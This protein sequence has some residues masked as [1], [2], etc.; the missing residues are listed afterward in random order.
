MS[1]SST[2]HPEAKGVATG[3][4]VDL[5][6]ALPQMLMDLDELVSAESPTADIAACLS[7]A[8]VLEKIVER[9]LKVKAERVDRGGRRHLCWRFGM[10]R[11]G[12]GVLLLG[13]LDTV[14]PLGTIDDWPFTL[15][16]DS[17]TGPGIFDMKAGLIQ[18][19]WAL[20]SLSS[21]DGVTLLVTSDE[22]IGSPTS[23]GLI[24]EEARKAAAVLVMEGALG[25]A[26]KTSRK[27]ILSARLRVVGRAAHAGLDPE[28]GVNAVVEL[29]SQIGSIVA[30]AEPAAGTTVVPSMVS[31]GTAANVVPAEA[32]LT[33]DVRANLAGEFDRIAAALQ[34][35]QPQLFGAG[36]SVELDAARP[37]FE[38]S[39]STALYTRAKRVWADLGLGLLPE[40]SAGGASDGNLTAALGIPTLDGLGAVG[41]GAHAPNESI[42]VESMPERAALV[43]ELISELVS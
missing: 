33:I 13:H 23:R 32:E 24:E 37:P 42:E 1:D 11:V 22:E 8:D 18:I 17:A 31:G 26:V 28:N 36:L 27:G 19:V 35:L 21:L 16:G 5:R 7:C 6:N 38:A 4:L 20:A 40:A 12:G 3:R 14:W 39:M 2:E 43:A 9:R 34:G 29:A 15:T 41:R 30:L 25:S 10:P